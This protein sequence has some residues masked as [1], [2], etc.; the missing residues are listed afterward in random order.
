MMARAPTSLRPVLVSFAREG[1]DEQ[2]INAISRRGAS[3]TN[4]KSH[5]PASICPQFSGSVNRSRSF[6]SGVY[7]TLLFRCHRSRGAI[8]VAEQISCTAP[9]A[10]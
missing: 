4:A 3:S 1:R 9:E 2:H 7:R 6:A 10:C 8:L 5:R